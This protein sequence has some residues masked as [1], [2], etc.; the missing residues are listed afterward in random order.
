MCATNLSLAY[1]CHMAQLAIY[2]DDQTAKRLEA[3][4]RKAGKSRSA[5]VRELVSER[6]ESRFPEEWYATFGSWQDDRT[7]EEILQEIRSGPEQ[8]E[9][10][11]FS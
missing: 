5:W 3:A 4:A 10:A 1:T 11:S 9:R 6:L 2:L 8:R 7:P